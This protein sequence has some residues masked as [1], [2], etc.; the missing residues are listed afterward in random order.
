M[1]EPLPAFARKRLRFTTCGAVDDGKSTLIGRLLYDSG[2]V[3]DDQIEEIR[4][5]ATSADG[6]DFA[7]VVDGLKAER[8]QGITIDVAYRYFTTGRRAF[9]IADA[10]GHEQYTRN[11][12]AAASQS[13]VAVL[14]VSAVDG[15][16]RQTRRH[17]TIAALFGI[18]AVIV[19]VNKMDAVGF[20]AG[21][22][23]SLEAEATA[24]AAGLGVAVAGIVPVAARDGDN[25]VAASGAMPWYAGPT[26]LALLEDCEVD[27][28]PP[29][30]VRLPVQTTGRLPGGGRVSLGTLASGRLAVG[31][32]LCGEASLAGRVTRL[33]RAGV[34]AGAATA[35]DAVAVELAPELDI[36]RG[37]I[38]MAPAEVLQ[39]ALQ[40][41]AR[42][43]WLDQSPLVAGRDYDCQIA[44][45]KVVAGVSRIEGIVD[46]DTTQTVSGAEQVAFN[47]I[48]DT[49]VSFAQPITVAPATAEPALGRFI[50]VDRQSRRTVAAGVVT[51]VERRTGDLPWQAMAVT[52]AARAKAKLQVPAVIWLTGLSGAG[53]STICDLLDRRLHALGRHTM[54]LDGDNLRHG[55]NA[56]LGFTAADRVENMR[57]VAHV[58]AL[59]ADAGLVVLVSLISP[60]VAER[61]RAREVIGT[62]RFVEVFVDA[63]VE[64]CVSRD[65]KG[66][67]ARAAAGNLANFTGVSSSY[68]APQSPDIHLRTDQ[69]SAE[70]AAD[71]IL[72]WL[73]QNG[74]GAA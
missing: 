12:A 53:K 44:T 61:R 62:D 18:R 51:S 7:F 56:D 47:E 71:M 4:R 11:Q 9:L 68:E 49:L 35:G 63:P 21:R 45:Q 17:L 8:E 6:L 72:K 38:L 40:V 67:Y 3:Y 29:Q 48:A 27:H 30:T 2:S 1:T 32:T 52:P 42:L 20:D 31:D 13:D 22:F 60:Y 19:A 15:I 14:V 34:E 74:L 39:P 69:V 10:P 50:L 70:D 28:D 65:P 33:W 66:H 36:G 43:V 64:V 46:L 54:V 55:L 37:S 41:R 59:M 23:A 16:R 24:L 57:R 73:R 25:I 5:A 26:L 58:A